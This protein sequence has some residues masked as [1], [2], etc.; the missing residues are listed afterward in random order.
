MATA[1]EDAVMPFRCTG[2][3]GR[4]WAFSRDVP[5]WST[6]R[7]KPW[8]DECGKYKPG[9]WNNWTPPQPAQMLPA[10]TPAQME[11]WF[12]FRKGRRIAC[13]TC[14]F[15]TSVLW[16]ILDHRDR[17]FAAR[18]RRD[19]GWCCAICEFTA[20]D[21]TLMVVHLCHCQPWEWAPVSGKN[22]R[23]HGPCHDWTP[24][25]ALAP[26]GE[27]QNKTPWLATPPRFKPLEARKPPWP[28]TDTAVPT[29]DAEWL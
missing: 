10:L 5:H 15:C 28:T 20:M 8:C 1:S 4:T 22:D 14:S 7:R 13:G 18:R 26:G 25:L 9:P 19:G 23:P 29:R 17:H 21:K 27:P 2:N 16:P 3:C 24:P 6:K 11:N 12:E